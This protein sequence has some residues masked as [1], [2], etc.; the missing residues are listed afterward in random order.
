MIFTDEHKFKLEQYLASHDLPVGL[1]SEGNA[2]SIAAINLVLTGRLTDKIPECMSLVLGSSV[3]R[4]QDA[5]P[6]DMRNSVRYKF[7]LPLMAGTGRN[8]EKERSA[9]LVDWMWST[10]LPAIQHVADNRGFGDAWRKMC[11]EKTRA[12]A[13]DAAVADAAVAA[14]DAAARKKFWGDVDPVS[15]LERAT[16]LPST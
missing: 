12:A 6:S 16:L 7:L 9:V 10:V 4:L 1:G 14:A 13:A 8:H 3:I 15:A 2:C 11:T 5:M